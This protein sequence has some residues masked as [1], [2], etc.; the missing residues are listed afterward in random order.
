MDNKNKNILLII[1]IMV[2]ILGF[3]VG[4][5]YL[6]VDTSE[7]NNPVQEDQDITDDKNEE[8][9]SKDEENEDDKDIDKDDSSDTDDLVDV[10]DPE[11]SADTSDENLEDNTDSNEPVN[12]EEDQTSKN[13]N[14]SNVDEMLKQLNLKNGDTVTTDEYH[15]ST[16]QGGATYK[17]V[18]KTSMDV[19]NGKCFKLDNGLYAVFSSD[20]E[21]INVNQ[22]GAYG[23]GIHDDSKAISSMLENNDI[24][25]LMNETYLIES[26]IEINNSNKQIIG[27]NSSILLSNDSYFIT[28]NDVYNV[29]ISDVTFINENNNSTY[30]SFVKVE[31]SSNILFKNNEITFTAEDTFINNEGS[32]NITMTGNT[33]EYNINNDRLNNF[34]VFEGNISDINNNSITINALNNNLTVDIFDLYGYY[35]IYNN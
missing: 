3:Y 18:D 9:S 10:E 12:P 34:S 33:I 22:Y 21:K 7:N 25:N 20:N 2:V 11:D 24:V 17:I 6:E 16:N 8:N 32:T 14:V 30:K 35:L 4:Y 27:N 1:I 15:F 26:S 13:Y 19:D 28:L 23:D 31:D 5:S 29:A